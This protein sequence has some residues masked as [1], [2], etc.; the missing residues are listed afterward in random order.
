MNYIL[1]AVHGQLNKTLLSVIFCCWAHIILS[2]ICYL[3]YSSQ[4]K[5]IKCY[6]ESFNVYFRLNNTYEQNTVICKRSTVTVED[7]SML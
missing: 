5:D 2:F 1:H 7:G 6:I 4:V 3:N